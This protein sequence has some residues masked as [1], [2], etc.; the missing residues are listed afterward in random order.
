MPDWHILVVD[1]EPAACDLFAR[2]LSHGGHHV[3]TATSGAEALERLREWPA[4]VV[5]TDIIMPGMDGMQL[6]ACIKE[7]YPDTAVII[8][9][10]YG[11]IEDAVEAMRRGAYNFITKPFKPQELRDLVEQ[12]LRAKRLEREQRLLSRSVSILELT[13]SLTRTMEVQVL[14]ARAAELARENFAVDS[15]MI[16]SYRPGQDSFSLLAHSGNPLPG[17][18]DRHRG[19]TS[20]LIRRAGKES[21]VI[22][23]ADADTQDCTAYVPLSLE[24]RT[25]GVLV[26]ARQG[27]PP[28]HASDEELLQVFASHLAVALESARLYHVATRRVSELE[29]LEAT[30]RSL[31]LCLDREKICAQVLLGALRLTRAEICAIILAQPGEQMLRTAPALADND[32]L[33]RVIRSKMVAALGSGHSLGRDAWAAPDVVQLEAEH[34]LSSFIHVPLMGPPGTMGLLAAFASQPEAFSVEDVRA[35]SALANHAATAFQNARSIATITAMYRET[36]QALAEA[37]DAKDP[38]T[39]GHSLQV[40]GYTRA[41]AEELRLDDETVERLVD[42][43]ILHDIGKISVPDSLL[44]KPVRLTEEEFAVIRSHPVRGADM[45]ARASHLRGLLPI[46]RHHHERYDGKGYPDRLSGEAIP[47]EARIVALA[48]A[49]DAI[50]SQ[51]VYKQAMPLAE[52]RQEIRRCAGSQFDPAIVE[53]FLRL[54]LETLVHRTSEA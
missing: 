44:N 34:R 51:R 24:G 6:L 22:F 36:I 40:C 4:D 45:L 47:F 31:S 18:N 9:T 49:F 10:G 37:V 14:P 15:V 8:A 41:L 39:R 2:V 13:R 5:V 54:P 26:L 1:D 17:W 12:C 25:K 7:H 35:L 46:V 30:S 38:Y 29:E 23:H 20:V 21:R 19:E 3:R 48:D 32:P 27:G 16:L 33:N 53:A 42:G 52:A 11:T 28:F 43:A 50:V